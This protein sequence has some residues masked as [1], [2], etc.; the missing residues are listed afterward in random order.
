LGVL[1]AVAL[2]EGKADATIGFKSTGREMANKMA[3]NLE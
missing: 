1:S 3:N 2:A